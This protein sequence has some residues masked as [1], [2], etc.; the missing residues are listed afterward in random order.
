MDDVE[1][2]H[3]WVLQ[4]LYESI[5]AQ[6]VLGYSFWG[7]GVQGSSWGIIFTLSLHMHGPRL[8]YLPGLY[9]GL[10]MYSRDMYNHEM[11]LV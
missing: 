9:I 10:Y 11:V 7:V 5:R 2:V 6:E 3:Y 1:I 4:K 8:K